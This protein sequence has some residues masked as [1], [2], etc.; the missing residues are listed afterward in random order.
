MKKIKNKFDNMSETNKF[1]LSVALAQYGGI[2]L[3][4][5]LA[6]IIHLLTGQL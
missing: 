3:L 6:Y 1:V 5:I 2:V 4:F